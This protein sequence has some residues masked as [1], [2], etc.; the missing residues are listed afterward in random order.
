[1]GDI[2]HRAFRRIFNELA[3]LVPVSR[4]FPVAVLP[5]ADNIYLAPQQFHAPAV[6]TPFNC[7]RL[8]FFTHRSSKVALIFPHPPEDR[9]SFLL[10]DLA[11]SLPLRKALVSLVHHLLPVVR[12]GRP[13]RRQNFYPQI[14]ASRERA[15]NLHGGSD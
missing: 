4:F 7:R 5:L 14:A 9:F 1:L 8:G 13:D 12:S 11:N 2:P 6:K 10:L 15:G 3:E